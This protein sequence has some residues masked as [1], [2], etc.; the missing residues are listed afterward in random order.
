M[1]APSLGYD[2]IVVSPGMNW[3]SQMKL[4]IGTIY[5]LADYCNKAVVNPVGKLNPLIQNRLGCPLSIQS[6]NCSILL[7]KSFIQFCNGINE[8]YKN[9]HLCGTLLF[10]ISNIVY[11]N[12]SDINSNPLIP[13]SNV[14]SSFLTFCNNV[15]YLSISCINTIFNGFWSYG[16][17]LSL[18]S[19]VSKS[20]G[21]CYC[22]N[23]IY[24]PI[25]CSIVSSPA[26]TTC[27]SK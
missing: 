18:A 24:L 2:E 1:Y 19:Q 13:L 25:Y 27:G 21:S 6:F 14:S 16:F 4:S 26:L 5:L 9:F 12:S 10:K 7:I 17:T 22:N 3:N 23:T 20:L 15:L 8:W 11:S